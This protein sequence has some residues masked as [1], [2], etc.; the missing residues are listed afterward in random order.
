MIKLL[1][2]NKI[3]T[4]LLIIIC[5]LFIINPSYYANSCLNAVSVWA[6]KVFPL[7]FPF[8]IF[9]RLILNLT[10]IKPNAMDKFFS[11]TYH[12]PSG[13]FFVFCL[14]I[15]CG[16]PMGAKLISGLYENNQ[17]SRDD[18]KKMLSFCSV[19][20][21]MFMIGTVGV[22]VLCSYKAGLI[23]FICNLISALINGIIF[24]GKAS[25]TKPKYS[26]KPKNNILAD[27]VYDSLISILMVGAHIILSFLIIDLLKEIQVLPIISKSICCVF[28]NN[29]P[30]NVVEATLSGMVE[31]TRGI[32]DLSATSLSLK[33]KTIVSG[34][35]IGFGGI[36]ILLQSVSFLTKLNLPIKTLLIQKIFQCLICTILSIPFCLLLL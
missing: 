30:S 10:Q 15:M 8:F 6:F 26:N 1:K 24:R 5:L 21:P 14:S 34:G 19:S 35:L 12:T 13:S 20:G 4:S 18:A 31:I 2:S 16:Y 23:I 27:S 29:I 11:K 28:N 17:I 33:I 36:S 22:T 32:I 9:T 7:L 25:E 3:I